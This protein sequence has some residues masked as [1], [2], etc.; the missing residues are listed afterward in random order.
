M[1]SYQDVKLL[2]NP[3]IVEV[4]IL[5]ESFQIGTGNISIVEFVSCV[6]I[7]IYRLY[8]HVFHL[9]LT[10]RRALRN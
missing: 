5:L 2:Q 7:G 3:G 10:I 8:R 4:F 6:E 9:E 1:L